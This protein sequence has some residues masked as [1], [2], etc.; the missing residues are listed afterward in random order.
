MKTNFLLP[1]ILAFLLMTGCNKETTVPG[2]DLLR[3]V[4]VLDEDIL[5]T[6]MRYTQQ[7]MEMEEQAFEGIILR[8]LGGDSLPDPPAC[9]TRTWSGDSLHRVLVID[10]GPEPCLCEDGRYRS[11][12]IITHFFGPR[13]VPGSRRVVAHDN[14]IVDE[15]EIGGTRTTVYLGNATFR[16]TVRDAYIT[17]QDSTATWNAEHTIKVL[18]GF[19]TPP[20]F[21]DILRITGNRNGVH[22]NGVGYRTNITEPLIRK[23]APGCARHFVDGVRRTQT[24]DGHEI[25]LDFDPI[26]GAPC[27]NIARLVIDGQPRIIELR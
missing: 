27:D 4:I 14:Y 22:R 13:H 6:E 24:D 1:A 16:E 25:I 12:K 3:E 23:M 26:G 2:S 19:D 9:M 21:D 17:Y 11:G 10:F 18:E 15:H 8:P 20:P 5:E 7:L